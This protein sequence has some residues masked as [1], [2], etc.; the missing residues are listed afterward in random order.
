MIQ[1]IIRHWSAVWRTAAFSAVLVVEGI[2]HEGDRP[3]VLIIWSLT[4]GAFWLMSFK[5]F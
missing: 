5:V 2:T 1:F 3:A 4:I